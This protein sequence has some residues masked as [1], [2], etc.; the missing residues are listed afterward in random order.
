LV[1]EGAFELGASYVLTTSKQ[2]ALPSCSAFDKGKMETKSLNKKKKGGRPKKAIKRKEQLAVMCNLLERKAIT[3][4]A[5]TSGLTISEYLR[6][7]G[8]KG[9]IIQNFKVLPG[10]VLQLLGNLNHIAANLNQIAKKRNQ[11]DQ[12]NAFERAEL[13]WI[14]DEVKRLVELI[15]QYFK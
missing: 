8:V 15:K 5:K 12:L 14:R 1:I 4:K 2:L 9:R 13:N 10:E 7:L 6:E 11:S 3:H